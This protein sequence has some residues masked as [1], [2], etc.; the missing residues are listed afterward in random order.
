MFNFDHLAPVKTA[1]LSLGAAV[2]TPGCDKP[3]ALTVRHAGDGNTGWQNAVRT[4][5]LAQDPEG[6]N[7]RLS[8]LLSR[9]VVTGWEN[10]TS[11]D[12]QP[13]LFTPDACEKLLLA[14]LAAHRSDVVRYVY[15]YAVEADN[16]YGPSIQATDLGKG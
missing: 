6:A 4:T 15:A 14:L 10:V 1:R 5:P 16:F 9:H 8:K 12:G 2:C 7:Q 3:I 11:A 13:I